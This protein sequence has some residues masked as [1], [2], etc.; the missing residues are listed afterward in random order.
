MKRVT[1]DPI[2]HRD[3]YTAGVERNL[4]DW[5]KE[6]IFDSLLDIVSVVRTNAEKPYEKKEH[7]AIWDA[8]LAGVI[9][10]AHGVFSGTFNAAI[11]RELRAI[12]A[13]KIP[14]GF[15]LAQS[16][17]PIVL[18]GVVAQSAMRSA[19]LH[20]E[21]I[22]TIAT[23]E[24]HIAAAPIG[25][26]FPKTVDRIVDDLQEQ[27]VQSVS[28][29][30]GLSAV[31][32]VP[33]GLRNELRD[34]L[35]EEANLEVKGFSLEQLQQLRDDVQQNLAAGARSDRLIEI[36]EA[37][38]GV[39]KRRARGIADNAVS[40]IVS[41]F[42]E[43]RYR[44]IGST[45]YD[46]ETQR[47]GR[48]REDHRALDRQRFSWSSKPVTNRATGARNHPGEDHN[49]RCVARPVIVIQ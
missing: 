46:W 6:T 38:F 48:E 26:V 33:A 37:R 23:M 13:R 35:T 17:V 28:K 47:D 25:L 16:E 31:T 15:A 45:E 30:E 18:R 11:S 27:F 43:R 8:L 24:E 2:H 49:C 5:F 19:A 44:E 32:P 21:I 14:T 34:D 39:S 3:E 9:W 20:T 7:S 12:G 4:L 42:R 40:R 1:A 29:V 36:I 41:K 10:Y 22:G